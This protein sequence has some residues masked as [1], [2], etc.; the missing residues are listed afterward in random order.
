[1][2]TPPRL[3]AVDVETT[4]LDLDRHV[5]VEVAAVD[6]YSGELFDF[7]TGAT[8]C[9]ANVRFDATMLRK[10]FRRYAKGFREWEMTVEP[11]NYRLLDLGSYAAGV[12][13][14][15]PAEIQ[16]LSAICTR[17]D[18]HNSAPHTALG[19]AEATAACVRELQNLAQVVD[20]MVDE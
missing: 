13:G 17:L 10:G 3:V 16:S 20:S 1:M 19:D 6:V 14:T 2:S 11:W 4:G 18:V 5:V 15:H 7:L 12:I 9:G 8:I